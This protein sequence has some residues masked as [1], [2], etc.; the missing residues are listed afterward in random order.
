MCTPRQHGAGFVGGEI[1]RIPQ[2]H[3]R[4][5]RVG[6]S[7]AKLPIS[8]IPGLCKALLEGVGGWGS[9]GGLG[10]GVGGGLPHSQRPPNM[11]CLYTAAVVY[12]K[13]LSKTSRSNRSLWHFT[14]DDTGDQTLRRSV[15]VTGESPWKGGGHS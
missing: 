11:T 3:V 4:M 8:D 9:G 5:T 14:E 13:C 2:G 7:P 10:A 15:E 6:A 1:A 12:V